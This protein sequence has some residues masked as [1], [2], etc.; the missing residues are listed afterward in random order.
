MHK[1]IVWASLLALALLLN[2]CGSSS[3]PG[4]NSI[5]GDWTAT[6]TNS[7]GSR[8]Y[9]FSATF[10]QGSGS[11]LSITNLT[12]TV[13]SSCPTLA[14]ANSAGGI[15]RLNHRDFYHE[16]DIYERGWPNTQSS[17]HSWQQHDLWAVDS[18]RPRA[19]MQ[20]KRII[21]DSASLAI[22]INILRENRA[23]KQKPSTQKL[24]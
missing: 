6:L 11:E 5:N 10:T 24:R 1:N 9:Q 2:G 18:E 14:E 15:F 8:A 20:R 21:H 12:Y 22:A 16:R 23:D 17:G 7:D 3:V 4:R 19:S 13:S